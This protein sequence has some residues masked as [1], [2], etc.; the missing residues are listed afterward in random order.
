M[1]NVIEVKWIFVIYFYIL[2][3]LFKLFKIDKAL[4]SSLHEI[5]SSEIHIDFKL[6]R[7]AI[8]I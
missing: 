8:L 7:Y 1:K 4:V 3:L 5:L 6:I 2:V